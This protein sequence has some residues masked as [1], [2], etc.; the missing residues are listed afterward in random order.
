MSSKPPLVST[1]LL[2][3]RSLISRNGRRRR[4]HAA[5]V[6][7]L[8]LPSI[9]VCCFRLWSMANGGRACVVCVV[10]ICDETAKKE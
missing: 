7:S 8:L 1:P 2:L 6:L 3:S 9:C 10:C 4:P 5:N